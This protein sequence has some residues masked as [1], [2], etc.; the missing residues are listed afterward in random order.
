MRLTKFRKTDS[1]AVL[2]NLPAE[3]Q[4]EIIDYLQA[5]N[6][7][8]SLGETVAWLKKRWRINASLEMVSQFRSWYLMREQLNTNEVVAV[9]LAAECKA[10]GWIKTAREERAA[11]QVFFN[12]IALE[13]ADA[14]LWSLTERINILKDRVELERKKLELQSKKYGDE[15]GEKA[16]RKRKRTPE[17]KQQEIRRILGTE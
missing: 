11:A 3:T 10:R 6:G 14:K 12:R 16:G 2:K 17:E 5:P 7:G 9:E 15:S 4:A 8:H 13:R 1:R